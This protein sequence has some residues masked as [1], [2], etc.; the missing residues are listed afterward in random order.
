MNGD[1]HWSRAPLLWTMNDTNKYFLLE[2][3][4]YARVLDWLTLAWDRMAWAW[5]SWA[6]TTG[7]LCASPPARNCQPS[8]THKNRKKKEERQLKKYFICLFIYFTV[9][10]AIV[11]PQWINSY[12]FAKKKTVKLSSCHTHT[13]TCTST[14][15]Q[16]DLEAPVTG[17]APLHWETFTR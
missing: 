1:S 9:K 4:S 5:A 2:M 3:M 15:T 7:P 17:S 13:C 14:Y 6:E 12:F 16:Q 11:S 8:K 10:N